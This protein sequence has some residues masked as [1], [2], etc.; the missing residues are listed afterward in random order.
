M[1]QVLLTIGTLAAAGLLF[2]AYIGRL[3]MV[4]S[5]FQ[6]GFTDEQIKAIDREIRDYYLKQMRKSPSAIERQEA[7]S[8]S[9][10]VEVTMIKV[11][12]KRLEGFATILLR[13]EL[14]K[15]AGLDEV[16]VPCEATLGVNSSQYL[17]KCQIK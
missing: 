3:D 5:I 16:K 12:D 13:D 14:S 4:T 17:W 15:N 8:G 2:L 7:A 9:T 10:T 11:S 6:S 1:K